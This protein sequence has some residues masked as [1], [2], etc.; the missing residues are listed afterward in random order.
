MSVLELDDGF[1]P[2][3]KEWLESTRE[4]ASFNLDEEFPIDESYN[5]AL[6]ALNQLGEDAEVFD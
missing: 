4:E 1:T 5:E 3:F 6:R 2:S